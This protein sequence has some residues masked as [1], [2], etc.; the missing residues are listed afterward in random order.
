MIKLLISIIISF[1]AKIRHFNRPTKW[2]KLKLRED[3]IW[4]KLKK[5]V[6]YPELLSLGGLLTVIEEPPV[7][8][9]LKSFKCNKNNH[10]VG[11][12][13]YFFK[14]RGAFKCFVN[15]MYDGLVVGFSGKLAKDRV[16]SAIFGNISQTK[17]CKVGCCLPSK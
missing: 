7:W 16:K 3:W 15:F 9:V 8:I 10:V 17:G 1:L 14:Y 4:G 13:W 5:K 12:K 6:T 11:Q 2:N